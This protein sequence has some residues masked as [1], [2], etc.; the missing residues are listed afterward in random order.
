[1]CAAGFKHPNPQ[2][3]T[4]N[5][6]DFAKSLTAKGVEGP[7]TKLFHRSDLVQAL[8]SANFLSELRGAL[9]K[10][11]CLAP[12]VVSKQTMYPGSTRGNV[13]MDDGRSKL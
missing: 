10:V 7:Q 8:S 12:S 11:P 2:G 3:W 5:M 6:L 4:E 1:M 13:L 9:Y